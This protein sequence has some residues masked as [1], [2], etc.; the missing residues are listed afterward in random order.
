MRTLKLFALAMLIGTAGMFAAETANPDV[1]KKV[2]RNQIVDLLE[3]PKFAVDKDMTVNITFTF[4]S[5]GEIV[6]LNV[7]SKNREVLK[8]IRKNLN[9]QKLDNPGERDKIYT[10][11]LKVASA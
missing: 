5:E 10:M 4:S 9:Y 6:V 1:P 8:Y 11:P 3:T 2:I 7:D